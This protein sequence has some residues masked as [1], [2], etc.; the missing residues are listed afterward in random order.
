[1]S[2][3]SL[4]ATTTDTV[5]D[6]SARAGRRISDD[7]PELIIQPR[8]GFI[9]VDWAELL[10]FRELLYFLVWRDVKVKY[11]QA[12]LG[13]AWAIFVPVLSMVIYTVVGHFAG[14]AQRV[15]DGVPYAVYIYSGILPWVFLQASI[16]NGG[17]SL[18]NQQ[19]LMSKT[20][21]DSDVVITTALIPGKP[22]PRLVSE[23][24]VRGM[25]PGSVIVDLA[26]ERGGNCALTEPGQVVERDGVTVI[27]YRNYPSRV[28]MHASQMY[29]SNLQKLLALLIQKDGT[30][31][32]D[33]A[34]EIIAGIILK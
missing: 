30:L 15:G 8:R 26:A 9:G 5:P 10:R 20:I 11:K 6:V 4:P 21:A 32:V 23:E 7:A 16:S 17:M 24:A 2:Q 14:F 12:V 13:V 27:G 34:D 3:M 25:L 19:A 28:P 31:K 22:A 18:V 33:Q 29:S 1:M